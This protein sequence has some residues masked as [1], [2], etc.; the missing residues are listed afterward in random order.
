[1]NTGLPYIIKR[2]FK[3]LTPE[4]PAHFEHFAF[5]K[6]MEN[7]KFGVV[8]FDEKYFEPISKEQFERYEKLNYTILYTDSL[9]LIYQ[10]DEPAKA[11]A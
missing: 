11:S 4:A 8:A 1:M 10:R 9:T 2:V 5:K 7:E 3:F 6:E